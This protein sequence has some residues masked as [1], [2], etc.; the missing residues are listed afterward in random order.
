M[1]IFLNPFNFLILQRK[2]FAVSH[3]GRSGGL[4]LDWQSGF[5]L[6]EGADSNV[7]WQYKFSGKV[8]WGDVIHVSILIQNIVKM[9]A[10]CLCD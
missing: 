10:I 3:L 5:S 4:T 1:N 6:T 8:I 7:I 9:L 2:T